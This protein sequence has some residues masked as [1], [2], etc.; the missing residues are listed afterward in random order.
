M[1]VTTQYDVR[2]LQHERRMLDLY[3][4]ASVR[5]T[6]LLQP[7]ANACW[8]LSAFE[9]RLSEDSDLIRTLWREGARALA[10]GFIRKRLRVQQAPDQLLLALHLAFASRSFDLVGR[11]IHLTP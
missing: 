1:K 7:L 3:R 8:R 10:D 5:D 9:W 2:S 4:A 11:L 6:A